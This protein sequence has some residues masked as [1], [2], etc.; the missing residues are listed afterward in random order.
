MAQAQ[1]DGQ[2]VE[3]L[4]RDEA[5]AEMAELSARV[6][7][8][9]QAYHTHDAPEISDADYDAIKARLFR[10][11]PGTTVPAPRSGPP[12]PRVSAR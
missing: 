10:T 7:R 4:D 11:W 3:K 1:S 6:A 2:P 8:A 12:R 5:A 9:N